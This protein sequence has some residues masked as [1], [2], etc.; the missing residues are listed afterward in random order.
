MYKIIKD[1]KV[2]DVVKYADFIRF[3]PAGQVVRTSE[4]LAEGIIGTDFRTIYSFG[5]TTNTAA[6]I[7]TIE[8]ISTDEFNRLQS[9]LNSERE[10]CADER[11]LVQA[12]ESKIQSLSE[13]C[14]KKITEGFAIKLSDK[15][16]YSFKLAVEDQLN[17][18]NLENQFNSGV[19]TFVYHATGLPC[20]VF[21]RE[22]I[23]K[24]IKA[25]RKHVLYHTTYFNAA[26]Q[27]IFSLVSLDLINEFSY[28]DTITNTIKDPTIRQIIQD[29]GSN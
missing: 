22:D 19:K 18:L 9:L 28:G 4:D 25:Y 26:K 17:L 24:V 3:L 10:I 16:T 20:K 8:K 15:K 13:E 1:G 29:G 23:S 21:T 11:T 14:N 27:H 6:V 7:A 12:K 2:V 5:L